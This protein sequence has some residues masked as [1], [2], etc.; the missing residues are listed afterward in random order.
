MTGTWPDF[1]TTIA[2]QALANLRPG[3]W[4]ESQEIAVGYE[5]EDGTLG[6]DSALHQWAV[7][8]SHAARLRGRQIDTIPHIRQWLEEAGFVDVH[9]RVFRLPI[10][11]WPA[12]ERL[13]EIGTAWSSA[14][15]SGLSAFSVALYNA[16]FGLSQE[17]VELMMMPVR[18]ALADTKVHA[19][20]RVYV[21]W[22][23]KP[24]PGETA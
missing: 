16:V 7:D 2:E 5:S 3:G 15:V 8:M 12:D 14:C 13:R 23:R 21:V 19:W 11:G 17:E 24:Y 10:N 22:G 6:P 4:Y 1:K 18:K 20:N 9:E